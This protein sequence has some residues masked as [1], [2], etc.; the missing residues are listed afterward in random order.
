[1]PTIGALASAQHIGRVDPL[2][3]RDASST[4]GR[5]RGVAAFALFVARAFAAA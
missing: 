5:D 4:T 1:M 3:S 2:G